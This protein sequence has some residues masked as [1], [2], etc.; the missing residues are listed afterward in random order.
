MMLRFR[1]HKMSLM[2]VNKPSKGSMFSLRV[3]D[4]RLLPPYYILVQSTPKGLP[5]FCSL[6]PFR[7]GSLVD[8][9]LSNSEM[10]RI[11]Q[12]VAL[13]PLASNQ[14]QLT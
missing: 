5:D 12:K 13:I 9:F 1:K 11:Y 8:E 14:V 4:A 2:P 3:L 10:V 6:D 7:Y